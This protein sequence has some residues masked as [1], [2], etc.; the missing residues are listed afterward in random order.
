MDFN[1]FV[2]LYKLYAI[3]NDQFKI[4]YKN[5]FKQN[6]SGYI[7]NIDDYIN[8][9]PNE[10]YEKKYYKFWMHFKSHFLTRETIF[11]LNK[12]FHLDR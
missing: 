2:K 4:E 5:A 12:Y 7:P 1:T 8:N 10:I 9:P 3:V 11:P 6:R